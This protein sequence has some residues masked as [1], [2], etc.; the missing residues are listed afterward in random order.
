MSEDE[1]Q[2]HLDS[3]VQDPIYDNENYAVGYL[4]TLDV[5]LGSGMYLG[6][7][8]ATGV[9]EV[10]HPCLPAIINS[11]IKYDE[12]VKKLEISQFRLLQ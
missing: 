3:I 2:E 1:I 8:K 11:V 4:F 6:I 5:S 9:V 7:N 12:E 10:S